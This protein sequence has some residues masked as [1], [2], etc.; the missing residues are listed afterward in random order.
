M[1]SMRMIEIN[2]SVKKF[3]EEYCSSEKE[4]QYFIEKAVRNSDK[5]SI[6]EIKMHLQDIAEKGIW[7]DALQ[8]VEDACRQEPVSK[9]AIWSALSALYEDNDPSNFVRGKYL[10]NAAHI[11]A[12]VR[13]V[14]HMF[15]RAENL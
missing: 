8:K 5:E 13:A 12:M 6:N 14:W 9:R 11:N 1:N 7:D 15:L 2:E 3:E 4:K 10:D